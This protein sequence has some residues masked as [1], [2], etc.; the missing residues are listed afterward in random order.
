MSLV[1]SEPSTP[2]RVDI[3]RVYDAQFGSTDA[4]ESESSLAGE[5]QLYEGGFFILVGPNS[6]DVDEEGTIDSLEDGYTLLQPIPYRIERIADGDF[7]AS[8]VEG[9]IAIGGLDP[10]DAYQGLVAEI[11]DTFD[12]LENEDALSPASAAQLQVLR[13]YF[14]RS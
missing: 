12:T 7:L 2:Q 13:T 6:I 9:N 8:F 5:F 10:Q 3:P 4:P 1:W 11:L 14:V